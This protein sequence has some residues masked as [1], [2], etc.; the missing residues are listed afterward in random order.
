MTD[1]Q[2]A[3]KPALPVCV[4]M[5]KDLF[6][7]MDPGRDQDDE[8][9]LVSVNRFI[10]LEI[11]N[12][13]GVVANLAPSVQR[14]RLAKGSLNVLGQ[15]TIPVGI[16]TSCNQQDDDGLEYQF[17][18]SYL[19]QTDEV[20]DGQQLIFDTLRLAQPKSIVL[21]LIS[22]LTDAAE[23]L[24]K[25][26][27][28]FRTKV[29]RV[30]IM[31]GVK[32]KDEL[33]EL[34][35]EGRMIP[36]LTAQN[37]SFDKEATTYL[38]HQLQ[39]LEIPITVVSRHAATAARVPRSVYDDMAAT[40]HVCGTRLLEAQK[41]AIE[42]LWRRACL[43]AD[44]AARQGLPARCDKAWFSGA[45]CAGQGADRQAEDS[46]WDLVQTFNLYDPA[47]LI[48]AVPN[49]REHFYAASVVEVHGVEHLVVG[50]SAKNHNVR[51]PAE[52]AEFMRTTMV[53]SL[54]MS[55]QEQAL[56][57]A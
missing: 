51:N 21:L 10:R 52:L 15:C 34:D 41:L 40:G 55:M 20:Q 26:T 11:L 54:Q 42:E 57:V 17:A 22:G 33:P 18:V 29:R 48:A 46:I 19:S 31:G 53:K 43:P 5:F 39:D 2:E 8:D 14:A 4:P 24:R 6:L 7:F 30:V 9:V 49:L 32:V 35:E 3:K 36:D 37:H 16:G 13:L 12:V 1:T 38:Y 50:V 56:R 28:L 23:V 25:H 27:H 47:T 44:D 45:F